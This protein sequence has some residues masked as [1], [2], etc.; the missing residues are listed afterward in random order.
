MHCN[1]EGG[2]AD[3]V[4]DSKGFLPGRDL[5]EEEPDV[6]ARHH[7]LQLDLWR[8]LTFKLFQKWNWKGGAFIFWATTFNLEDTEP[9]SP[10]RFQ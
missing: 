10:P 9:G 3:R 5:L 1:E 7:V 4:D 8:G 6:L 2:E